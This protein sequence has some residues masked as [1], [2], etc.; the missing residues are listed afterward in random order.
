MAS[1]MVKES[2]FG[3]LRFGLGRHVCRSGAGSVLA[4]TRMECSSEV[5]SHHPHHRFPKE[6]GFF[7]QFGSFSLSSQ[8]FTSFISVHT[9]QIIYSYCTS[10]A[11]MRI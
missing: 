5:L 11:V 6:R 3:V 4:F 10:A 9:D 1:L 7:H 8:H 2:A